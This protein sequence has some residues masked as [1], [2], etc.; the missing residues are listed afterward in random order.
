MLAA[1]AGIEVDIGEME[2]EI[3]AKMAEYESAGIDRDT[4]LSQAITD[5]SNRLGKTEADLL[6]AL[7]KTEADILAALGDV[8][9]NITADIDAVSDLVGKPAAEVTQT[10]IDFVVDLIAGKQVIEENQLAQYDV[11]GDGQINI[12]DQILL[13]QLFAGEQVFDQVAPTSI[14]GKPATGVYGAIVDTGTDLSTEIDT[15]VDTA[16]DTI[17]ANMDDQAMRAGGR[18]FIQQALQAPDAAG[19]KVTVEQPDPLNLRYVY[20]FESIFANPQQEGMFPSP[21]AKG[22]QV[23]DTTD[24]LLNIIGD[25]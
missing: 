1:V 7:G 20:D 16:I 8:E 12:D 3:L 6:A 2:T 22:G 5:V 19:Q 14:Y 23:D 17:I 4:A 11:T 15:K 9:A 24:K 13:E 18:Q 21:Y 10:D 25:S